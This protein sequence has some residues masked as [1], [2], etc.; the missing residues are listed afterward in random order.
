MAA[1]AGRAL[2]RPRCSADWRRA[3]A[4]GARSREHCSRSAASAPARCSRSVLVR[5]REGRGQSLPAALKHASKSAEEVSLRPVFFT[6]DRPQAPLLAYRLKKPVNFVPQNLGNG[7]RLATR[8]HAHRSRLAVKRPPSRL[9][10]GS[11]LC[12]RSNSKSPLNLLSKMTFFSLPRSGEVFGGKTS[13][14]LFCLGLSRFSA[15]FQP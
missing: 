4:A 8:S 7:T 1:A 13:K 9:V 11:E 12:D 3:R 5:A 6:G 10:F 14:C 2:R 15:G